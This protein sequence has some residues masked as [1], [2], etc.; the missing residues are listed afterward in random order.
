MKRTCKKCGVEKDFKLFTKNS[1][2]RYGIT[3]ICNACSSERSKQLRPY[4]PEYRKAY[5]LANKEREN[6]NAKQHYI[7]NKESYRARGKQWQQENLEKTRAYSRKHYYL[8]KELLNDSYMKHVITSN[9]RGLSKK[10]I[11][12]EFIELKRTHL[13][14]K[15]KLADEKTN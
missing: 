3:H 10:N 15:R 6:E 11:P 1:N 14:L 5:Y 13:I 4:D 9:Y 2:C 7:N 12:A 8:A